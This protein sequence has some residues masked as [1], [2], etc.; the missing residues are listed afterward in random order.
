MAGANP[1]AIALRA[2]L[3]LPSPV[4]RALSGGAA[5]YVGGR[6]LEARFQFLAAHA[7]GS[8]QLSAQTPDEARSHSVRVSALLRRRPQTG[9]LRE[10]LCVPGGDGPLKAR[11]YRPRQVSPG[12]PLLVFAHGGGG[13]TGDL[14]TNDSFCTL[15]A[16]VAG[17]PVVSVAYRLAPETRFPAG[18]NDVLAACRWARDSAAAYGAAEGRIAVGGESFGGNLAAG[19]CQA[20]RQRGE[21]QPALQ[22]LLYPLLDAAGDQPSMTLYRQAWP[23]GAA[24]VAWFMD[25][26]MGR[27]DAPD[28]PRLS[29]LRQTDLAGLAPAVIACAGF[30]PLLD[31][32]E[33]Y[34]RRLREAGVPVAF[35]CYESLAHGFALFIDVIPAANAATRQIALLARDFLAEEK[36]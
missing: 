10:H 4:L 27:G 21:P 7:R 32:G 34:A 29:P 35:R 5:V 14:D 13:V 16:A 24:D 19:A 20:M 11:V 23:L 3:S 1:R 22:L 25:Q 31:Q 9:V 2:V 30:D 18:L 26:Y 6:T 28:D 33:A 15:V 36:P 8:T 17:W 12:A